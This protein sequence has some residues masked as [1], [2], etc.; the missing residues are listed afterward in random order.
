MQPII[1]E[2]KLTST[3]HGL[4]PE[5]EGWFVLNAREALWWHT[6]W[7]GWFCDFEGDVEFAE[8]GINL[9]VL[10]PG[11]PRGLYHAENA[12]EGFLVISGECLLV[13]ERQERRLKQ[14]DFVHCPPWTEHVLIGA[15]ARGCVLLSVGARKDVFRGLEIRFPVVQAALKHGAGVTEETSSPEQANAGRGLPTRRRYRAGD[16]PSFEGDVSSA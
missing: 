7:R 5:G 11:Q 8:V 16:L 9:N 15:G 2:A 12:Q 1:P 14:W 3:E 4:I 13:I 10:P 6:D